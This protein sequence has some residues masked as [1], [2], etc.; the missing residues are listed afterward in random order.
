MEYDTPKFRE[1]MEELTQAQRQEAAEFEKML[2]AQGSNRW[3]AYNQHGARWLD[4]HT[5]TEQ[6]YRAIPSVQQ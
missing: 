6:K 3:D 5:I 1:A 4:L 2:V